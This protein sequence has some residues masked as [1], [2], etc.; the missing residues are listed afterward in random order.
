MRRF[1]LLLTVVMIAG[2]DRSSAQ[3]TDWSLSVGVRGSYT[4]S[5]KVFANPD[6]PS[7]DVRSQYLDFS[8]IYGGGIEFRFKNPDDN[9]FLSLSVEYLSKRQEQSQLTALTTPPRRVEV[10]DGFR[11]IPVELGANIFIP[12]GS[13]TV[14]MAM[15]GGVGLYYG[16][17]I[18]SVAGTSAR[19][20]N[21]PISYGIHVE[22]S[23]DY[24][25]VPRISV[26]GE[27]RFRDPEV[28][29]ENQFEETTIQVNGSTV[30]LPQNSFR[31]KI[32]V[33][34]LSFGL[35]VVFDIF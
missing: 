31:T 35:G 32:N 14:R 18:L 16:Q 21:K 6:S 11:L 30:R 23:F 33:N 5:S 8:N 25:I 13:Q 9:F 27:M 2:A 19:Q 26:R 15:G 7:P 17:R 28:T 24:R 10:T 4:T 20:Q 22:S 34:G 1:L 12:L 3:I 29:A